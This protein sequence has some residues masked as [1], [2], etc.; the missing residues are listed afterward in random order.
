LKYA[1][2]H[3]L[4][5]PRPE[6][7][8]LAVDRDSVRRI[9]T[10]CLA[11]GRDPVLDEAVQIFRAYGIPV[12]AHSRARTPEEAVES[13]RRLGYPVVM[14]VIS[15]EI[16]HKS[17]IG[18]VQLNLQTDEGVRMAYADM[19]SR[20]QKR[21]PG[22]EIMGVL[23]QP[24][25]LGGRELILG[26]RQDAQFGPIVLLGM[27]GI[28]VEVFQEFAIRVVPFSPEEALS[29]FD[30]LRGARI[31][32]G[33]RGHGPYDKEAVV[34]C[35]FHLAHLIR[36]FPE[37]SEIDINPIRIFHRGEGCVALDARI[38]LARKKEENPGHTP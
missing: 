13:A 17:D 37:I 38:I 31:L 27:G 30:E 16:S 19:T 26:A 34:N 6:L 32:V 5:R 1:Q 25:V 28:F 23:L 4:P 33:A 24:M 2:S 36:D 10:A 12:V 22:A 11:E 8:Q 7:P 35:L 3:T 18:G 29:A 21:L 14:K 20:I 15:P 9:I